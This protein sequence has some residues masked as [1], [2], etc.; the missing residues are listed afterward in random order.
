MSPRRA[1]ISSLAGIAL[2]GGLTA[3]TVGPDYK[4]PATAVV[5]APSATG[6]FVGHDKVGLSVAP[7][8][9]RWWRL[10]DDP[11]LDA[12]IAQAFAANTDLRVAE[13]NLE[14]SRALLKVAKAARQPQASFSTSLNRGQHAGSAYLLDVV[15][16][17]GNFYDLGVTAGYDLDLF[18]GIRRGIEA[19]A[20]DTEAVEA[21]RDLVR[22]SVAAETARAYSDACGSGLQLDAAQH[23]LDLQLQSVAFTRRLVAGGR[24]NDLAIARAEQQANALRIPLPALVGGRRNALFRLA[25]LTGRPPAEYDRDLETCA[26]PPRVLAPLPIGDGAALLRRRPDVRA[27]ERQLAAATASIGVA[28]ASLYPDIVIG[29]SIGSTGLLTRAFNAPNT[30]WG[31]GPTLRWDVNQ[32]ASRA[33]I[34]AANA[35][36]KAAL[37]HFDGVVLEAL[38]EVETA[39]DLYGGDLQREAAGEAAA[40]DADTAY[41]YAVRLRAAGR[42]T[43]FEVL[44][45][46]RTKAAADQALAQFRAAIS[47]DQV[48]VFF[49]LG[50]GWEP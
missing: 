9:E 7:L 44:D 35:G 12:L 17:Q 16:P 15:L 49:V 43:D 21:A 33:R 30:H 48:G 50:G 34:L 31:W 36:A 27:A 26:T 8:P 18:G 24:A 5:Q 41:R 28:T 45:A 20:A 1:Q 2:A 6:P 46:Q 23:S 29:A 22:V 10:Y 19:Q 14:R 38:R 3:C 11:R 40:A 47:A 39:F 32:S 37:A 13:A 25:T 4:L 42:A